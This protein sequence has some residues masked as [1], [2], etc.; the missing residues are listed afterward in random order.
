MMGINYQPKNCCGVEFSK[1]ST[2]SL[3]HHQDDMKENQIQ[4]HSHPCGGKPQRH[5]FPMFPRCPLLPCL[6][7]RPYT[8]GSSFKHCPTSPK[9]FLEKKRYWQIPSGYPK[10]SYCFSWRLPHFFRTFPE[11]DHV[12]VWLVTMLDLLVVELVRNP[13]TNNSL[14]DLLSFVISSWEHSVLARDLCIYMYIYIYER[15]FCV[16]TPHLGSNYSSK[17]SNV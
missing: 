1:A 14:A 9:L 12:R 3:V 10:H 17:P 5:V 4:A 11:N 6:A 2:V 8:L 7:S 16:S 13:P 15:S